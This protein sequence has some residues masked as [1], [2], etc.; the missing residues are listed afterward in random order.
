MRFV[1]GVLLLVAGCATTP[2]VVVGTTAFVKPPGLRLPKGP[3]PI[4]YALDLTPEPRKGILRGVET[5]D[6]ELSQTTRVLWLNARSVAIVHAEWLRDGRVV[7][8]APIQQRHAEMVGL[9]SGIPIG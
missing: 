1:A 9:S 4:H 3:R 8:L 6:L 7:P 5:I 2:P